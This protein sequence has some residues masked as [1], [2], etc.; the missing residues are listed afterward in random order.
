MKIAAVMLLVLMIMV[1]TVPLLSD[2]PQ[3]D[4][5]AQVEKS[6]TALLNA[7]TDLEHAGGEWGGHRELA[8]KHIDEA[9][10]ELGEAE[11]WAH[12]HHEVK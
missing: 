11:K 12:E 6:H 5:L 3:P 2:P 8:I 9:L 7:R 10:K 1:P 4:V